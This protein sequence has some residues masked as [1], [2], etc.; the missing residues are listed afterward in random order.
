M[1]T[2]GQV[3]RRVVLR[4]MVAFGSG[5]LANEQRGKTGRSGE[6]CCRSALRFRFQL[7]STRFGA[8]VP[9]PQPQCKAS[10][11]LLWSVVSRS[12]GFCEGLGFVTG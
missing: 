12:A 10:D 6:F 4:F 5:G 3:L 1:V 8:Q 2:S 7:V 9:V 11:P